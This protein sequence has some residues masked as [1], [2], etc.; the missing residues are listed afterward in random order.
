MSILICQHENF[1]RD[2]HAAPITTM[3]ITETAILKPG[4]V[5]P[6][7]NR[8]KFAPIPRGMSENRRTM[9][10]GKIHKRVYA[11]SDSSQNLVHTIDGETNDREQSHHAELEDGEAGVQG[12][13][14][15]DCLALLC[16]TFFKLSYLCPTAGP[17]TATDARQFSAC[18]RSC[19]HIVVS[20]ALSY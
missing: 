11:K 7:V 3:V 12:C 5:N 6:E 19:P 13:R 4:K 14:F 15:V 9:A 8:V 16:K 20:C 1:A 17:I 18:S 10:D 2:T